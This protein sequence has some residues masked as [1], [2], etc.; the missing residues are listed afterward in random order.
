[1]TRAAQIKLALFAIGIVIWGYGYTVDDS[2]IRWIGIAF[3]LVAL[4]VR[5]IARKQRSDGDKPT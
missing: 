1:M 3:L 4:L 2:N 5:F